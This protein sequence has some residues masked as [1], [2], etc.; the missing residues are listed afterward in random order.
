MYSVRCKLCNQ[1]LYAATVIN[2]TL[3][4][5]GTSDLTVDVLVCH[6]CGI[7]GEID[8]LGNSL[9]DIISNIYVTIKL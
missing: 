1:L 6:N 8:L 5:M 7:I 9:D 3:I 2:N 4:T